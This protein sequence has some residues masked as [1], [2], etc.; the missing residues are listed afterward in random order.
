MLFR[1]KPQPTD[2]TEGRH[3]HRAKI[4]LSINGTEEALYRWLDH[5]NTPDQLRIASSIRMSPNVKD[6]TK[7]DCTATIEQWFVPLPPST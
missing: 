6:D 7:I 3:F 1:S 5:L 4:Q 2:S